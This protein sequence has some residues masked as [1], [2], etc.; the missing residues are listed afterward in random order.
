MTNTYENKIILFNVTKTV[1]SHYV[2]LL[3]NLSNLFKNLSMRA[4][5]IFLLPMLVWC[6]FA[7]NQ[8][9]RKGNELPNGSNTNI[10]LA[11]PDSVQSY[12]FL[13]SHLQLIQNAL[14]KA[15]PVLLCGDTLSP[16]QLAAQ[17]I[18]IQDSSIHSFIF[19]ALLGAPYRTEVFGVYPARES[20]LAGVKS[21]YQLSNCYRVEL[22]NYAK[23]EAIALMVDLGSGK[24][25]AHQNIEQAQP[26]IPA[27]LKSMAIK[28]AVASKEVQQALGITASEQSALMASTKTALNRSRCERSRHLCVAP[29]FIKADKALWAIVDLTDFRVVGVRWTQ[30]GETGPAAKATERKLQDDKIT[31]CFCEQATVLDKAGWKMNYML[32][33]SDG[34]RIAEVSFNGKPVLKSAK[35]VDWHVSYSGTDGFGYSDAIGCPYFSQAAVVAINA[36]KVLAIKGDKGIIIGFAL[37]QT[38]KSEGWPMPCNY[39]YKQRYEFFNDGSF[40]VAAASLGRGCGNDGTYRPVFRIAFAGEQNHVNEW[41]SN[42]W[43]TWEK[44]QWSV[45]TPTTAFTKEGYQFK[46]SDASG[47]GYFLEPGRGQFND[48][49]RGDRAFIYATFNN[50]QKDEGEA[51]LVTIGPC[52]NTDYQQGPEKFIQ[53]NPE[54][55]NGKPIV[56]WYVAQMKNEDTKG[57]EYCWAESVLE[58]G[59]YVTKSYPCFC[60]PRFTPIH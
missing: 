60:G 45:Y 15:N 51:D 35:L 53:P 38:F 59:V 33:S 37:E 26:D 13:Q 43:Q 29:T 1:D 58:K 48:G 46:I 24:V 44:E 52:C 27:Y 47:A 36:P 7:C 17:Q 3:L 40:R 23:N 10:Q 11:D 39:N 9:N 18:A 28:I 4:F 49:G 16:R 8:P 57:H 2:K 14:T 31:D 56:I 21:V 55:I 50:S 6:L 22:Y 32:T 25:L 12:P 30:V 19:D 20:D 34:L 54:S 41:K 5:S 42:Q